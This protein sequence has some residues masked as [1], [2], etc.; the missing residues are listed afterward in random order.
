MTHLLTL[1]V[2]AEELGISYQQLYTRLNRA[3]NQIT[4][5]GRV[6]PAIK[7]GKKWYVWRSDLVA[8][9]PEPALEI[10]QSK[11]QKPRGKRPA[12]RMAGS[13]IDPRKSGKQ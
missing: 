10:A 12:M 11:P 7:D 13:E 3:A 2:V 1:D 8:P 4:V 6:I 5:A 9:Q